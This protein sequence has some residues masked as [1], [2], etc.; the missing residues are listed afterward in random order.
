MKHIFVLIAT[1]AMLSGCAQTN[2]GIVKIADD[3]YMYSRSERTEFSGG[4]IKAQ[5]F[6]ESNE[7]CA[8]QGK[9]LVPINSTAQ[10]YG[11]TWANAEIQFR[12]Q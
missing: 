12:C 11:A 7:F 9:K 3:T 1:T 2:T 5:L 4:V 6:T 8:K 10:D